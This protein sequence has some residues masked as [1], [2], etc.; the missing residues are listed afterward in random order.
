LTH[1]LP[2]QYQFTSGAAPVQAE[3]TVAGHPFY[4]RARHDEW[5]FSVPENASDRVTI[6]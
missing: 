3:G 1:D 2:L 5:T 6:D 4:V